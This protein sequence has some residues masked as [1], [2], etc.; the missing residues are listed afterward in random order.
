[1]PQSNSA[2]ANALSTIALRLPEREQKVVLEHA[3]A[4]ADSIQNDTRRAETLKEIVLRLPTTDTDLLE[5][6][7]AAA[8]NIRSDSAKVNALSAIASRLS[9]TDE[10]LLERALAAADNLQGDVAKAKTLCTIA[11]RL[12]ERE[13]KVV[14]EFV[15]IFGVNNLRFN[16]DKA[17]VLSTIA[18]RLPATDE[19]LL[20]RALTAAD[21]LQDDVAKA[22][23]LCTI[24]SRLPEREQKVVLERALAI[25]DTLR[26]DF[27]RENALKAI[28]PHLSGNNK[29]LLE[30][31]L[32]A[33]ANLQDNLVKSRT[34][35]AI[36]PRLLAT[37]TD[38]LGHVLSAADNLR[39]DYSVLYALAPQ[40]NRSNLKRFLE[41]TLNVPSAA[42]LLASPATCFT[43]DFLLFYPRA[44][45]STALKIVQYIPDEA[46]KTKFLSALIPRLSIGLLSTALLC[47][48]GNFTTDRY[49]TETFKNL[50]PYLPKDQLPEAPYFINTSI[51]NPHYKTSAFED[52]IPLLPVQ[53]FDQILELNK[54]AIA[55][56]QHQARILSA[57]A[58]AL[59]AHVQN[60]LSTAQTSV[61]PAEGGNTHKAEPE[62]MLYSD[63]ISKI[64]KLTQQLH[65]DQQDEFSYER[66]ASDIF[67]QLVPTLKYLPGQIQEELLEAVEALTDIS[68]QAAVLIALASNRQDLAHGF[69]EFLNDYLAVYTGDDYRY[70]LQIKIRLALTQSS[71]P[72]DLVP[73]LNIPRVISSPSRK[74]EA[75]VEIACHAAG[76]NYQT[77]ALQAIR[78][79]MN[80]AYLQTQYL[81]RLIPHLQHRQRLEAINVIS[82]IKDQNYQV[83]GRVALARRFP[84]SEIFEA[85]RSSANALGSKS[86]KIT[87]LSLLAIDIP[88]LLPSIIK[89]IEQAAASPESTE[90]TNDAAQRCIEQHRLER[91][92]V[93]VALAPHLPMRINREVNRAW[94]LNY[95]ISEDL[96]DRALYILARSY[97]DAVHGGSLRNDSTEG[98]DALNLKDE[99]DALS[100]L[101]LLRDLE[102]PM[103]VGILGGWGGGKV[104]HHAPDAAAH[105]PG[106]QPQSRTLRNLERRPQPRTALPLRR[107][108]LPNQIRRLDLC[109]V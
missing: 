55:L 40:I 53:L 8:N 60:P 64:F 1:V 46:D 73:I 84:E 85:A 38:L 75:W 74:A 65:T 37:D 43:K 31:A 25:I 49:L 82:D 96:W 2:K 86:Q 81:Q 94:S 14:L 108:H 34:L 106:A 90:Q 57:I 68:H 10:D 87:Q 83:A 9:A 18:S 33:V 69:E 52:L 54:G 19:D 42:R 107:P 35:R 91:H 95:A 11:S 92:N 59:A 23:T 7:L 56:P 5:R 27:A 6:A 20:E 39:N 45:N 109:Q 61:V 13:Q 77:M 30:Q 21:N 104:L 67:I 102:P 89:N 99:I 26:S 80:N 15:L 48:Q 93:L 4:A 51:K 72:Q 100:N 103:A 28:V 12:P 66:A 101:L 76:S 97:R 63:L 88:E 98:K 3:L 71:S 41:A 36:A 44:K 78:E 32:T 29:A 22:K 62:Q 79:L 24:A 47:I 105:D 70:L 50:V 58:A 16:S 17:D